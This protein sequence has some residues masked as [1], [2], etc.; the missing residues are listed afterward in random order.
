MDVPARRMAT[1]TARA[2]VWAVAATISGRVVSLGA[3]VL[4]A[5]LLA[6]AEFGLVAVALAYVMYVEAVSD[7]GT[8]AALIYWPDDTD[9]AAS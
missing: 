4:L 5:R 7:L 6:P 1:A 3:L 9:E 2:A 8:R